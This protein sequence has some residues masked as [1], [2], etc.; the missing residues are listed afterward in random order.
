MYV[1][2]LNMYHFNVRSLVHYYFT[3]DRNNN[4][5]S[6]QS[7]YLVMIIYLYAMKS[8][9]TNRDKNHSENKTI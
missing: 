2:I 6:T 3:N 9:L 1:I 5:R 7:K 8:N 4:R